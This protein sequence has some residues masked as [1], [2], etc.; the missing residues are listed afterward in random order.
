MRNSEGL[1]I[2]IIGISRDI[3][4]RKTAEEK[5]RQARDEAERANLAKSKFLA[6]ASHDLRQPLQSLVL[7]A[8]VLKGYVEGGSARSAGAEAT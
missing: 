4:R 5:L 7:F 6:S 1:V 3:T 8:G 2:G